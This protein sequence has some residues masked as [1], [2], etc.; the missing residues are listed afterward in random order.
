MNNLNYVCQN[1]CKQG[2]QYEVHGNTVKRVVVDDSSEIAAYSFV[3]SN[4]PNLS[5]N[6]TL[7][8]N[9][10]EIIEEELAEFAVPYKQE[11]IEGAKCLLIDYLSGINS[12][13]YV[14]NGFV[15]VLELNDLG[16][17]RIVWYTEKKNISLTFV[18]NEF[19][20]L[21][22]DEDNVVSESFEA[23]SLGRQFGRVERILQKYA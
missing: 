18:N 21:I 5:D 20:L 8:E 7:L 10:D 16:F 17:V 12:A 4:I 19:L 15:P 22:D 6:K 11:A 14:S 13:Q 2:E 9:F 3:D 1:T 23:L